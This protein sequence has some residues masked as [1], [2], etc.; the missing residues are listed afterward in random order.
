MMK[1]IPLDEVLRLVLIESSDEFP[2]SDF[3][4]T[5]YMNIAE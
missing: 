5:W 1:G 4:F 3:D 2:S